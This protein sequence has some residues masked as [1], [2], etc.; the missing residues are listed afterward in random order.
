M[1]AITPGVL[2]TVRFTLYGTG[3]SAQPVALAIR[4]AL[5]QIGAGLAAEM[6]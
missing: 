6:K 1:R 5:F 2:R 4:D 3:V